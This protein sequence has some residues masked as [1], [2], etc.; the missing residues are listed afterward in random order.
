M[1]RMI[2][3]LEALDYNYLQEVQPPN[4]M[5]LEDLHPAVSF[6]VGSRPATGALLGGMLPICQIPM[7]YHRDIQGAWSNPYYMTTMKLKT[8]KQFYLC[9][10][11]W[12]YEI[13][14]P[15]I[16]SK[17]ERALNFK[18][19][20]EDKYHAPEM[21]DYFLSQKDKYDSYFAYIHFM[22]THYPFN[23]P[24]LEKVKEEAKEKKVSIDMENLGRDLRKAS[25]LFVDK[26]VGRILD[27]CKDTQIVLC[28]DHNLPPNIVSAAYDVPSPR[29]ML[30]FIATTFK[31]AEWYDRVLGIDVVKLAKEY[32]L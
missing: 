21:T 4:I 31:D 3:V 19:I 5:K 27:A 7:C 9:S 18:W 24:M 29:T 23:S 8:E 32:W 22:E 12:S 11:G 28:S 16:E 30:S 15:W 17:E 25:L 6:A 10:N 2:L 14:L 26:Q 13:M 20:F 1:K